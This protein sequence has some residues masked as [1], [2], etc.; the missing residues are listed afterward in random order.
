VIIGRPVALVT[1]KCAHHLEAP[2][3][4]AAREAR[5][6][7][8]TLPAEIVELL[9]DVRR[10]AH[11]HRGQVSE[12]TD[13]ATDALADA[14]VSDGTVG[15]AE[16]VALSAEVGLAI[17]AS[18]VRDAARLRRLVGSRIDGVWRFATEAVDTWIESRKQ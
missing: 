11:I 12:V 6:A 18:G 13:V 17:T 2:L 8:Y 14:P 16:V 3:E 7:G 15:V 1:P 5:Q 4:R 10:L 9:S